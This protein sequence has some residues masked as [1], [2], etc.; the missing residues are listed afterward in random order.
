ML[1]VFL[2]IFSIYFQITFYGKIKIRLKNIVII[3]LIDLEGIKLYLFI[4]FLGFYLFCISYLIYEPLKLEGETS[5]EAAPS[6]SGKYE[7]VY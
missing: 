4:I 2:L 1:G 6:F 7:M 5:F 3:F